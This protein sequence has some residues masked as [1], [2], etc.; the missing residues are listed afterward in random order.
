MGQQIILDTILTIIGV[1]VT[2]SVGY[3]AHKMKDYKT[4]LHDKQSNEE[5]QNIALKIMLQNELTKVYYKYETHKTIP[6]YIYTNWCNM[7]SIY[8]KL[9]GNDYIHILAER[10]KTWNI[11]KTDILEEV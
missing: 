10:M 4:R 3:L 8:E 6:D 11:T 5:T 2:S 7:L 1:I 9:D